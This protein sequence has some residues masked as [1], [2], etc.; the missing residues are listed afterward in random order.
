M[1]A[2]DLLGHGN[3]DKPENMAGDGFYKKHIDCL[4]NIVNQLKLDNFIL[5]GISMGG[6]ISIG[7]TLRNPNKVKALIP[8]DS[9]GIS[10]KMPFHR[11]CYW[12]VHTS[13]TRKSFQ[14]FAKYKWL[15]KLILQY[16]LI[17][18]KS[19]ITKELIDTLHDRCLKSY[20]VKSMEDCL[21][22]SITKYNNIQDFTKE[23]SN[24]YI[25]V[26]FING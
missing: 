4:E 23:L 21:R 11:L 26:L 16:S 15:I 22:S 14:Y 5:S 10:S 25:P 3:S 20:V 17:S 1:Y 12:Y 6:A 2:I 19:K 8:V 9:W 7:Y 24:I 13:I 18:D